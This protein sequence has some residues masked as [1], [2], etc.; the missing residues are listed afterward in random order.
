M[1]ND[2]LKALSKAIQDELKGVVEERYEILKK[3]LIEKLDKDKD[4]VIAG[5]V[6]NLE[7]SV[8]IDRF[9]NKLVIEVK[10]ESFKSEVV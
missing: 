3:E 6:L 4:Q 8:T 5:I 1:E 7:K 9:E 2:F 10:T